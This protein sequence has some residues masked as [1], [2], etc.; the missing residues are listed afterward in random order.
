MN[1]K[2][3]NLEGRNIKSLD[4]L[5]EESGTNWEAKTDDLIT[6]G[7]INVPDNKAVV[8]AEAQQVLGIVGNRYKVIQ[9]AEA[10]AFMDVICEK[11]NATYN[12][13]HEINNGSRYIVQAKI[14]DSFEA[15]PGDE[16]ERY[17]TLINSFDGSSQVV[18]YFTSLRMFCKNQLRASLKEAQ[19]KV[20]IRHTGD[21]VARIKEASQVLH[22]SEE[23]FV[24]F[25]K[26]VQ[27]L[28]QKSVDK[29]MV[30]SFLDELYGKSDPEAKRASKQ[31]AKNKIEELFDSGKGNN[32]SSAWDI[33]NGV[34][35]Y[36]DHYRGK[37]A[38]KRMASVLV[39]DAF[40]MKD[41]AF[42]LAVNI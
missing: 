13:V 21:V 41:K 26:K 9:N 23:Y 28:A 38:D 33:Y 2:T 16:I 20:S 36:L 35:E 7:G 15:R 8:R 30:D 39:G 22:K 3:Y 32:G 4:V 37:E 42:Q 24:A 10:F 11:H 40:K 17:I 27:F 12:Y 25:E 14:G 5:M 34:T 29:K 18:A 19:E 1:S 31:M 6:L